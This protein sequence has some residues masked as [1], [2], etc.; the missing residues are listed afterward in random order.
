MQI[1]C[2][3]FLVDEEDLFHVDSGKP[4]DCDDGKQ[5]LAQVISIPDN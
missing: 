1:A 3:Y 5:S 4:G 2:F